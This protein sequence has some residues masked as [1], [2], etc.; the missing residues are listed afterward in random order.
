MMAH[1]WWRGPIEAMASESSDLIDFYLRMKDLAPGKDLD[2]ADFLEMAN[3][4]FL[5]SQ[6]AESIFNGP[7]QEAIP[8]I[9][10]RVGSSEY[11]IHGIA[12]G[13][14]VISLSPGLRETIRLFLETQH[15]PDEG[16]D[17]FFE[18]TLDAG[19][20][21]L[22]RNLYLRKSQELKD[23]SS[24]C[25][26]RREGG[27][28][29]FASH[30]LALFAANC[31][32]AMDHL[33]WNWDYVSGWMSGSHDRRS[34]WGQDLSD[35]VQSADGERMSSLL[36]EERDK[37]L[38]DSLS[39]LRS[40]YLFARFWWRLEKKQP[41]ELELDHLS[42]LQRYPLLHRFMGTPAVRSR[43]TARKLADLAQERRLSRVH[44]LGG[45]AHASQIDYFLRDPG[46]SFS[47]LEDFF[48]QAIRPPRRDA[49]KRPGE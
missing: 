42:E 35:A 27:L 6:E 15:C 20:L 10:R 16:R 44:Y 24:T 8:T 23:V 45:L 39:S 13:G 38:T 47:R 49:L 12:H 5:P 21:F 28:T 11:H 22:R 9:T 25:P 3:R 4:K 14:G 17:Y 19:S 40:Q 7:S 37:V 18:E 31:L 30:Y 26:Y 41:I 34:G 48:M 2:K 46:Y 1:D 33:K 36:A 43:W 32:A 29:D